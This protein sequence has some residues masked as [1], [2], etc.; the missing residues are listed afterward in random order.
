[1]NDIIMQAAIRKAL[2]ELLGAQ[3]Y[4][5]LEV[6]QDYQPT[7]QGRVTAPVIYYHMLGDAFYGWQGRDEKYNKATAQVTREER[8]W[9]RTSFQ[10]GALAPQDPN[11]L[12]LPT[13]KDITR[14]AA[15]LVDSEGFREKLRE[16]KLG[17]EVVT[18]V[19]DIP[20]LNDKGRFERNPSFDFTVTWQQRI[21]QQSQGAD[22]DEFNLIRI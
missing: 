8:Q 11:N 2:M 22:A 3:G 21:I 7:T 19:R 15:M 10:M 5:Q 13:A 16:S 6:T 4:P 14:L 20:F 18:E 17:L 1:M 9:M 12:A